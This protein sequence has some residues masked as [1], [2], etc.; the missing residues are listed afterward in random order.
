[1][2]ATRRLRQ[3]RPISDLT[4]AN[5]AITHHSTVTE[6]QIDHLGHMNVRFYGENARQGSAVV[7][8]ELSGDADVTLT[9]VFVYTRHHRE[10][11][12]GARLLVRS[13]VV[14]V[15][16]D[17]L[18]L[19]HELLNEDS[20]VVAATFVHRLRANDGAALPASVA[21][22]ARARLVPIPEQGQSRSID[23]ASDPVASAPSLATVRERDL[24]IRR[25]RTVS[26]E[27]CDEHGVCLR[28]DA[29]RARLGWRADP[30][31]PAGAAARRAERRAHGL[32]F[33]GDPHRGR[34]AS[35]RR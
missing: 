19:Y 17:E 35:P 23:L 33:D 12:L 16:I 10:Q 11:L 26:P 1:M 9:P 30:A 24:A 4:A 29:R 18:R 13:G 8:A 32:G 15:S 5:L 34:A 14:D 21:E 6:D 2:P 27:E 7:L 28:A 25:P 20:G 22:R 3:D 31:P